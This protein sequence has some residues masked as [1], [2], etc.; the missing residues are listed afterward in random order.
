MITKIEGF[1]ATIPLR[2]AA[3]PNLDNLPQGYTRWYCE[4]GGSPTTQSHGDE[5]ALSRK[6]APRGVIF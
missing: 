1:P 6:H 5:T 2:T 3:I 4:E